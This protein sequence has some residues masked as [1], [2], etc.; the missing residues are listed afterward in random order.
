LF[1]EPEEEEPL[2]VVDE[3]SKRKGFKYLRIDTNAE[4][5]K[6]S[7]MFRT[8]VKQNIN[9]PNPKIESH[10]RFQPS[11]PAKHIK[12][13]A[14]KNYRTTYVKREIQGKSRKQVLVDRYGGSVV[15]TDEMLRC[16][17]RDVQKAR[18]IMRSIQ[19]GTFP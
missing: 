12:M 19:K 17:S 2:L 13:N 4:P 7:K 1:C 8:F 15:I 6:V 11:R 10:A 18:L 9:N 3:I 16:V 5:A 14:L